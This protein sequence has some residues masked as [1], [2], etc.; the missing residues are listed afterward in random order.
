MIAL[1]GSMSDLEEGERLVSR[2]RL[3]SLGPDWSQAHLEKAQGR[4]MEERR[5]SSYVE[6]ARVHQT[7]G[8]TMAVLD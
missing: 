6:Q 3:S 4:P 1:I 5:L 2:L 8:V 7:D